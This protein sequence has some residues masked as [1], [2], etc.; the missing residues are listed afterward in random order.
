MASIH[1]NDCIGCGNCADV[2]R[3]DAVKVDTDGKYIIDETACEGCGVCVWSCPVNAI[4]FDDS[5]CGEYY[6]S[7]TRFGKMV[8]AKLS[9]AAENSGK[10]VSVVRQAHEK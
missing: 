9:V 10:L 7:D 1:S 4:D 5:L 8:H 6:I 2:C 3:F